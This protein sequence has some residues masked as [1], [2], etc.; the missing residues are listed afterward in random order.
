MKF[1]D[2]LIEDINGFLKYV[3]NQNEE[4]PIEKYRCTHS[5][6]FYT[7]DSTPYIFRYF[8]ASKTCSNDPRFYQACDKRLG[9]KVTNNEVLCEHYL[10]YY[11]KTGNGV[12][13]QPNII[14][15]AYGDCT[16]DC[17]NT[18]LNKEGCNDEEVALPTG[19][20]VRPSDICNDVCDVGFTCEDEAICNGYHYGK[21]CMEGSFY[22]PA[23][24]LCDGYQDCAD[25]EDEKECTVT[26]STEAFCTGYT[27]RKIVPVHNYMKCGPLLKSDYNNNADMK[28]NTYCALDE[29]ASSQTNC[30]QL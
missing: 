3:C 28:P 27:T 4:G 8:F 10:C 23:S 12:V 14:S 19:K 24:Y 21:Y 26:S 13:F 9:G 30:S 6:E 5:E 16:I 1:S 29:V 7:Q 2:C 25:G 20:L 18:V 22:V 11:S 17:D 15:T